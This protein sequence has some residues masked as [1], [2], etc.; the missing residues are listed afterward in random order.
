MSNQKMYGGVTVTGLVTGT[1]MIEDIKVPVPHQIAVFIPADLMHRSKDLW[2]GLQQGK[3]F[4]LTGGLGLAAQSPASP[5]KAPPPSEAPRELTALRVENSR[6][7]T[8]LATARQHNKTLQEEVSAMQK[9]LGEIL[10]V[11]ARIEASGGVASKAAPAGAPEG[12]EAVGGEVPTF[13]PDLKTGTSKASIQVE[14]SSVE[15]SSIE[16]A[17]SR[18]KDLRQKG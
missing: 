2:R 11:L 7:Q 16:D 4:K 3:L 13:M 8:E 6:L 1:Y 9:Q 18:L 5:I 17:A 15:G 12:T 10:G 14:K